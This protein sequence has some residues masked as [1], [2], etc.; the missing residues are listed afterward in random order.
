M[1]IRSAVF[2]LLLLS[3]GSL[4]AEWFGHDFS[5][6]VLQIGPDGKIAN[7]GQMFVADGRMRTELERGDEAIVEIVDLA[8]RKAILLFPR[9]RTYVER[10]LPDVNTAEAKGGDLCAYYTTVH[11]RRVDQEAVNGRTAYK[12]EIKTPAQ[13]TIL[14][15]I[16]SEHG[17]TVRRMENERLVSEMRFVATEK[18]DGRQ[19]EK[20]QNLLYTGGEDSVETLQWYDP[21]LNIA[22]RQQMPDGFVRELRNIHTGSQ[23]ES[24]FAVPPDY[25]RDVLSAQV[26]R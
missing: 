22:I 9:T 7:R 12:W 23:P 4:L 26:E 15:W 6:A 25:V 14:Q 1:G 3:A 17:F 18:I 21:E 24:L 8:A 19:T 10:Q 13:E 16:D 2:L 5:A 11:C 20:W